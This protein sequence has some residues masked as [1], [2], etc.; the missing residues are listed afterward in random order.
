ML[1]IPAEGTRYLLSMSDDSR[2]LKT[3]G[4]LPPFITQEDSPHSGEVFIYP[5]PFNSTVRFSAPDGKIERIEIFNING[6]L[7]FHSEAE[8]KTVSW[9]PKSLPS[10]LYLVRVKASGKTF[11][12]RVLFLR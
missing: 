11:R 8:G 1:D 10:G 9:E 5:N 3:F 7:V 2:Y 4:A 12:K 6:E